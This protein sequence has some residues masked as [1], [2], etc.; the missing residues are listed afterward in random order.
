MNELQF[1]VVDPATGKVSM[2]LMNRYVKGLEKLAQEVIYKIV[3]T[4]IINESL[5]YNVNA[6]EELRVLFTNALK[7]VEQSIKN[8]QEQIKNLPDDE[9]L[10]SLELISITPSESNEIV[11]KINVI[12]ESGRG[13]I[14]SLTF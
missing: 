12:S 14:F 9:R 11:L 3:N 6:Q 8:E 2:K 1:I 4:E 7:L 10:Y 13:K 5:K